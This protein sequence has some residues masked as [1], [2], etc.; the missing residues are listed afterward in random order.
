MHTLL[1]S[2]IAGAAGTSALNI[3]SYLDM[4]IRARPAS[5]TPGRAVEMLAERAHLDLGHGEQADDRRAALGPLLGYGTGAMAAVC[6]GLLTTSRRP[7]WPIGV[8]LLT[9]LA[10]LG[11]NGPLAALGITDPRK[12]SASDWLSDLVPHLAYGVTAYLAYE[13]PERDSPKPV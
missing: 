6:Y 5:S 3:A 4:A 10:M 8:S 11:S 2:L 9:G 7:A 13:S 12:W 1:R